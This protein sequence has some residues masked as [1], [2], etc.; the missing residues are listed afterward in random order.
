MMQSNDTIQTEAAMNDPTC[1]HGIPDDADPLALEHRRRVLTRLYAYFEELAS[2]QQNQ[3]PDLQTIRNFW[4]HPDNEPFVDRLMSQVIYA[5]SADRILAQEEDM[6]KKRQSIRRTSTQMIVGLCV[7]AAWRFPGPKEQFWKEFRFGYTKGPKFA[8]YVFAL[9]EQLTRFRSYQCF[10][11]FLDI[12]LPCQCLNALNQRL[13]LNHDGTGKRAIQLC[14]KC[15]CSDENSKRVFIPCIE[16]QS[17]VYCSSGCQKAHWRRIHRETCPL[18]R[19]L[20]FPI[21][22]NEVDATISPTTTVGDNAN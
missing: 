5:D 16:C 10:L 15:L 6:D 1:S 12:K 22:P 21:A 13:C 19:D 3:G 18:L 17:V 11:D 4:M 9:R 14:A 8:P 2:S 7:E 20:R